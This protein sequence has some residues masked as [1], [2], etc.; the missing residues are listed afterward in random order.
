MNLPKNTILVSGPVII[1]SNKV[2]LNKEIKAGGRITPWY[3]PGGEV[4]NFNQTL[5]QACGREAKEEVGI[6]IK[7]IKPLKNFLH[8]RKDGSIVILV[9]FLAKRAGKIKPGKDI[10]DWGWHDI[11]KLPKD[12]A[13]NVKSII[14]DY[15][16]TM[17]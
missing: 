13:P 3:F 1:E 4:E 14:K 8:H 6:K 2:L 10:A 5:E 17:A 16:K 12:C 11:F 15:L 9:H 7:I